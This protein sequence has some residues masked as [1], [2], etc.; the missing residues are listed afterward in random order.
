MKLLT[1]PELEYWA[2]LLFMKGGIIHPQI[3]HWGLLKLV[4]CSVI[5]QLS[6]PYHLDV[7]TKGC[8]K[9]ISSMLWGG[10]QKMTNNMAT[11]GGTQ[12]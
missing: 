4:H 12:V 9:L 8:T 6:T 10:G 7:H 1:E 2:S 3:T 11:M 5:A